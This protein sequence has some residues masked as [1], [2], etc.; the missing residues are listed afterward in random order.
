[1]TLP[2]GFGVWRPDTTGQQGPNLT[3][4]SPY[5]LW[6]ITVHVL[7]YKY[8]H[9]YVLLKGTYKLILRETAFKYMYNCI[10]IKTS[11]MQ[12][13]V[14]YFLVSWSRESVWGYR[15]DHKQE[16]E[17]P[18]VGSASQQQE[19]EATLDNTHTHTHT[20]C[21]ISLPQSSLT[22]PHTH[23]HTHCVWCK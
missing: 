3:S 6:L 20:H 7:C 9:F 15:G 1:M 12:W 18:F 2:G 16:E 10:K 4:R 5:L 11:V 14:F 13:L 19:E 17:R 22:A 23:T 8:I 21:Q